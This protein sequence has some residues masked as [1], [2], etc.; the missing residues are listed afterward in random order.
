MKFKLLKMKKN[1]NTIYFIEIYNNNLK[2]IFN[3][4]INLFLIYKKVAVLY[5]LQKN[6]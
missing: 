4:K 3:R 1:K 6:H 5:N 2:N